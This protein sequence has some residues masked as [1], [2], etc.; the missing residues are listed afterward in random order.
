MPAPRS[1]PATITRPELRA[2]A[3]RL[4]HDVRMLRASVAEVRLLLLEEARKKVEYQP[5]APVTVF[6]GKDGPICVP[7]HDCTEP[8][9]TPVSCEPG[10]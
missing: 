2:L 9:A 10:A 6:H 5:I 7:G 3:D 8:P 4:H 1:A